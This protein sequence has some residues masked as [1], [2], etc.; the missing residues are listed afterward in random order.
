MSREEFVRVVTAEQPE[1]PAYFTFD[2]QLNR[3]ERPTLETSLS[4]VLRPHSLEDVLRQRNAG[5]CV[6]DARDPADYA[7]AHLVDSINV[8]LG[9]QFATWAGTLLDRSRPILLVAEPGREQEAATRLGRIGFDH[10]IGY[11]EGGMQ[12]LDGRPELVRTTDRV[13]AAALAEQLGSSEAP[14]LIDVRSDGER[15]QKRI[16]GSLHI[17]LQRLRQRIEEVP[18]DRRLAVYCAAGY[19]SSMAVSLFEQAGIRDVEDLVGGITAWEKSS[20]PLDLDPVRIG[21][22]G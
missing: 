10:V 15:R 21:E 8:G 16:A 1:A 4:R 20:L 5:A 19:R 11:L 12:A 14:L 9:G 6:L 2:A 7:G 17:P 22:S 13:T 18:R 3:K